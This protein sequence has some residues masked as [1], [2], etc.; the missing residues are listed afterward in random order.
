M[1]D[2]TSSKSS[3][4]EDNNIKKK[5]SYSTDYMPNLLQDSQKML[6]LDHRILYKKQEYD[7]NST[8]DKKEKDK[9]RDDYSHNSD[10]L[11]DYMTNDGEN[12]ANSVSNKYSNTQLYGNTNSFFSNGNQN[13]QSYKSNNDEEKKKEENKENNENKE[14]K[15]GKEGKENIFNDN[16][17][18]YNELSPDK[19]MLKRLD[20]LRKLGELVQYGVKLSQ[21]YNMN[22]DY[23]AM[24]YEYELHK[25]IRAKQNSVNWMSSLMLNC[26]Y[27]IEILNEKYN[28][29]DLKLKNWSEQINADINNYYDVFGEIYEKYNQPGKNM[30]PELKLVLMI[31]GSALKFHLNNTL[32]SQNNKIPQNLQQSDI[33]DPAMLEQMRAK[34]AFDKIK[35]ETLKNNELLKEKANKEHTQALKQ[36]DDMM[37]LQNKKLE[38]QKQEE[39]NQKK[40]AEFAKMK[41]LLEQ[42]HMPNTQNTQNKM[43][44]LGSMNGNNVMSGN[45]G[46]NVMSGNNV[47]NVMSGINGISGMGAM[48]APSSNGNINDKYEEI[49]RKNI[50]DHLQSIKDKVKNID[51][52]EDIETDPLYLRAINA[53]AK[54]PYNNQSNKKEDTDRSTTSSSESSSKT[55]SD[56]SRRKSEKSVST[57]LSKRKYNKKG[58]TIQTN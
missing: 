50:N 46:N 39:E 30:A 10:K 32:L 55:S 13:I 23:F 35:D 49:R 51:V 3:R 43:T 53:K 52:R 22:S 25:N 36:M 58:I 9:D 31:S 29:F 2:S 42:Q 15:E 11:S 37:F 34:A 5:V 26:I 28:P 57:T 27:G 21:N 8:S 18:D 24:K 41:M 40:I 1:T 47:N 14:G 44:N 16:Y 45:N 33:Q 6:P 56:D 7:N 17:D 48:P 20:M 38:I 4:S 12:V 19:Q 54:E